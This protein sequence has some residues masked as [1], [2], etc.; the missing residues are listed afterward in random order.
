[1]HDDVLELCHIDLVMDPD[2]N[3]LT[4]LLLRF[5]FVQCTKKQKN[6]EIILTMSCWYSLESAH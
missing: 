6:M 3:F 5:T 1:M 2:S 4:L